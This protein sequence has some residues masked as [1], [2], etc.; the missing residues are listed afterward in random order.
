MMTLQGIRFFHD[1]TLQLSRPVVADHGRHYVP[2][3]AGEQT[4]NQVC[5]GGPKNRKTGRTSWRVRV[6]E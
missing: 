6:A 3:T 5:P 1:P 4:V 2:T